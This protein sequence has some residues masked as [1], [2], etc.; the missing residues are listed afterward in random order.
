MNAYDV[1]IREFKPRLYQETIFNSCVKKNTLVVLPTGLGKTNVFLMLAVHRLNLYPKSKVVL[2]GPTKPLVDQYIEVFRNQTNIKEEDMAVFTG[3]VAP[4]KR[5]ELWANA[6]LVFSTPQ[7]FEND[8]ITSRISLK[9]VSLIGFDEAHRA[10]KNYSYVWIAKRYSEESR[11]FKIIGMTAS[12]GSDLD[13]IKEVCDNL[14]IED[15]EIRTD[16]DPDVKPYIR[17]INLSWV[18]IELPENFAKAKGFLEKSYKSKIDKIKEKGFLQGRTASDLS[19]RDILGLQAELRQELTGGNK[20]FEVMQAISLAA[21]AIKIEHAIELLE[22]QDVFALKNYFDKLYKESVHTSIKASKNLFL[23]P[24]FRS[25]KHLVEM[26]YENGE[27]HPKLEKIKELVGKLKKEK[28]ESKI[29][30]FTQYRDSVSRIAEELKDIAKVREFYGQAKKNGKG[31]SQKEQ[32]EI[33]SL[34][35]GMEFD[36]LVSTSVA[37]EGLD[38]PMVDYVIFYEPVPSAI[39]H[40]QRRGRT[41]RHDSGKVFI[42]VTKNTRDERYRWS[43][44]HKEKRMYRVLD[45]L[46]KSLFRLNLGGNSMP[47]KQDSKTLQD[48]GSQKAEESE[49]RGHEIKI[50]V[51]NREKGSQVIKELLSMPNVVLNLA[52]LEVGDFILSDEVCI[53]FKTKGDFVDSLIDKRVFEQAKSLRAGYSSP[54][55]MVQ[56]TED[57]FSLRNINHNAIRGFISSLCIDFRI[58]VIFTGTP[59]ET[60]SYIYLIAKREQVERKRSISLH[61]KKPKSLWEI[62]EYIVSSIPWIGPALSKP[63]LAQFGTI[64]ELAN[65]EIDDLIKLEN[66]GPEKAKSIFDVLNSKYKTDIGKEKEKKQ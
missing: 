11:F 63:L 20:Q 45:G 33:L 23:D 64:R 57:L 28:P 39:R 46:K 52:T 36:V 65:A 25:A 35:S 41:G 29:L 19:K 48:Y 34:F 47:E 59:K 26:I 7:G 10:T 5:K 3:K 15:I 49:N 2:L 22:T 4:E 17:G 37:E 61:Q 40:I 32:K 18:Y 12:P 30:V 53:E 13:K 43:A 50:I 24:F 6:R 38:I 58:P 8:L 55:I 51:D 66:I 44:H 54:V 27:K 42:L 56:G 9:E 16:E 60:A 21:E 62:Q 31:L 14:F 1:V